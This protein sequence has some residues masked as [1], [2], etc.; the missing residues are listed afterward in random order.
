MDES[1]VSWLRLISGVTADLAERIAERYP[2]PQLL[3]GAS[4]RDLGEAK[5][6]TRCGA[7]LRPGETACGMCAA[8]SPPERLEEL[9]AVDTT[10]VVEADLFLCPHCGAFLG[11]GAERCTICGRAVTAEEKVPSLTRKE[12]GV[13]KDFLSRWQRVAEEAAPAPPVPPAPRTI[14]DELR[15][16][17]R[18]IEAD[19]DL[20]RAWVHKA[21]IL[22]KLG[23]PGDAVDA[24][25]R[26]GRLNPAKDDEYRSD[27]LA[28]LGSDDTWAL[29]LRWTL[30]AELAPV[31]EI[32][33]AEPE[34]PSA[35]SPLP[36][37]IR[38]PAEAEP[39]AMIPE[40]EEGAPVA[41]PAEAPAALTPA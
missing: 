33:P 17:E 38:T 24:F 29:P 8:E 39:E 18:L 28:A 41:P 37:E 34:E 1:Y 5:I 15:E 26:A 23:R 36:P 2:D 12:K 27:A 35:P 3:R 6:C 9:P 25:D 4:P 19:P 31:A 14:E 11:T 13:S 22:V 30:E 7:F 20:E 32:E 10:P 16:Y 21:R 40:L